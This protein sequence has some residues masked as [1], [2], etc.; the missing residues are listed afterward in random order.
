MAEVYSSIPL[1]VELYRDKGFSGPRF[2]IAKDERNLEEGPA[3]ND[4]VSSVKVCKGPN[5]NGEKAQ[6]FKDTNF[7]GP[8]ITLEL[9]DFGDIHE[10]PYGFG[11][12]ISSVRF[13]R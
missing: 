10:A 2:Y 13:V 9:G 8:S 12:V 1:I 5:W 7:A 4:K 6:F 3:F 11:D